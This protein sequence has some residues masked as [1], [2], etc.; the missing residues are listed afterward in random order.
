VVKLALMVVAILLVLASADA[1]PSE[2][3]LRAAAFIGLVLVIA[4]V[5]EKTNGE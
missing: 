1:T 5:V 4:A 3:S 2:W